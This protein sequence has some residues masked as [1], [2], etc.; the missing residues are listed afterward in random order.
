MYAPTKDFVVDY[1]KG[2]IKELDVMLY[3]VTEQKKVYV[4]DYPTNDTIGFDK[5][6][7]KYEFARVRLHDILSVVQVMEDEN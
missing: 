2:K 5:T 3:T 7:E 4:R 1:I 6:I